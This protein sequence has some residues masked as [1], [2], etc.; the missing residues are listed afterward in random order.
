MCA[1]R[2]KLTKKQQKRLDTLSAAK[3]EE[4]DKL[5]AKQQVN[6]HDK[7]AELFDGYAER[8]DNAALKQFAANTLPVDQATSRRGEEARALASV[9]RLTLRRGWLRDGRANRKRCRAD[10]SAA[11]FEHEVAGEPQRSAEMI[12]SGRSAVRGR[13][14]RVARARRSSS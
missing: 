6:A 14:T 13:C 12:E 11:P 7:A 5:Y 2:T 4:F 10:F 3:P 1:F 8:G 9:L